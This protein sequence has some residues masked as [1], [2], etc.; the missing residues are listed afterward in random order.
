M[1]S[2]SLPYKR[3][4]SEDD[5]EMDQ[6]EQRRVKLQ[7]DADL[8]AYMNAT[9]STS[10]IAGPLIWKLLC[11][12]LGSKHLLTCHL[13]SKELVPVLRSINSIECV[14]L[15]R[16]MGDVSSVLIKL[17]K[18]YMITRLDITRRTVTELTLSKPIVLLAYRP[19]LQYL[20]IDLDFRRG[21]GFFSFW[22]IVEQMDLR[23]LRIIALPPKLTKGK[24]A[25][26]YVSDLLLKISGEFEYC[27][28]HL[29][30]EIHL[31]QCCILGV[32]ELGQVLK[33]HWSEDC[34]GWVVKASES[35]KCYDLQNICT[36]HKLTII[37]DSTE[38]V[39]PNS[40]IPSGQWGQ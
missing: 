38:N 23:E 25:A 39:D 40:N 9:L 15:D 29:V 35:E 16:Q 22:E 17:T 13:I 33:L 2:S 24:V 26:G 6:A 12:F 4:R 32:Q 10:H 5:G 11:D 31:M 8:Y 37:H 28:E 21:G 3:L 14:Q 27:E 1:D 18:R 36:D 19:H 30:E 20:G 7:V 34:Q